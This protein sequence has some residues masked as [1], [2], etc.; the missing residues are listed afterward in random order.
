MSTSASGADDAQLAGKPS[1]ELTAGPCHIR[2]PQ[3]RRDRGDVIDAVIERI[4]DPALATRSERGCIVAVLSGVLD[5]TRSQDLREQ[6]LRF[7]R[8]AGSRLV[9]DLSQVT[10]VDVAGLAVLVGTRRRARLFGGSLRLAAVTAEV[11]AAVRAAGLDRELE[12]FPTVRTAIDSAAR[13]GPTSR[14]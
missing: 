13:R 14:R 2:R 1:A 8:P 6:L 3:R 11:A 5:V 10:S 4:Q 7:V 9:L 12:I